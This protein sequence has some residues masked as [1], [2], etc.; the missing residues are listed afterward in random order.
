M[1]FIPRSIVPLDG[2]YPRWILPQMD[3]PLDGIH[4]RWIQSQEN[5]M[6][7]KYTPQMELILEVDA[8]TLFWM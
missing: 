4:P 6:S 2:F 8:K 3:L 5:L 1:D 7:P